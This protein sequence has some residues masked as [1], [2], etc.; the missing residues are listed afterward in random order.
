[1][2][3]SKFL[4]HQCLKLNLLLL[5]C[6]KTWFW[7]QKC[8]VWEEQVRKQEAQSGTMY[9]L[10][11]IK[12]EGS[13]VLANHF[14]L[15]RFS[16]LTRIGALYGFSSP[17]SFLFSGCF[18]SAWY[19]I[20]GQTRA[21]ESAVVIPRRVCNGESAVG[22]SGGRKL[23]PFVF[24]SLPKAGMTR[25]WSWRAETWVTFPCS[26]GKPLQTHSWDFCHWLHLMPIM[27]ETESERISR[28]I[29][30]VRGELRDKGSK[31]AKVGNVIIKLSDTGN[32]YV[33]GKKERGRAQ[34]SLD[35]MFY[36]FLTLFSCWNYLPRP[37]IDTARLLACWI[38]SFKLMC[39]LLS[40]E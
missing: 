3:Y 37:T 8:R 40:H 13:E 21:Q 6:V 29:W 15:C 1:M 19:W 16:S 30:K 20:Q 31:V 14:V 10:A 34:L 32:T 22:G 9:C 24:L 26:Q 11:S 7:I 35:K 38:L 12:P 25:C 27:W 28:M 18:L 36:S 4:F 23:F 17:P 33:V 39:L 5:K 2:F